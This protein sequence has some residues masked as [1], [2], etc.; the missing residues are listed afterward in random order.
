MSHY[1]A[2]N[3]ATAS[4]PSFAGPLALAPSSLSFLL[5]AANCQAGIDTL[6]A[7]YPRFMVLGFGAAA[8]VAPELLPVLGVAKAGIVLALLTPVGFD[9]PPG[10][11]AGTES[12]GV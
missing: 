1:D 7:P 3:A 10:V 5:C 2:C 6:P 12:C 8:F 9:A 11:G 4:A